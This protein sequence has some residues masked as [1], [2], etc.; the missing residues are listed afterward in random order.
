M[1]KFNFK[2]EILYQYLKS[3]SYEQ[4]LSLTTSENKK[5]MGNINSAKTSTEKHSSFRNSNSHT[6]VGYINDIESLIGLD[7]DVNKSSQE[8]KDEFNAK[9]KNY[10]SNYVSNIFSILQNK[11]FF[12]KL[13]N[14]HFLEIL[15]KYYNDIIVKE[16]FT[17]ISNENELYLCFKDVFNFTELEALEIFDL[18]KFN[19][20]FSFSEQ[21]FVCLIYLFAASE[22]GQLEECFKLFNEE[23]FILINGEENIMSLNRLKD[24]G[25]LLGI[26]EKTLRKI[27]IDLKLEISSI[28]DIEKFKSFY[29]SVSSIHDHSIKLII[30]ISNLGSTTLKKNNKFTTNLLNK[31]HI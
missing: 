17:E 9:I 12:N 16:N 4:Q 8:E 25:R 13:K 2:V 23:I 3:I 31:I 7:S 20:N 27:S 19:E 22:Y 11:L 5:S 29:L 14:K 10:E 30:P 28:I 26:R 21:C 1:I 24:L 6:K 15:R 18:F